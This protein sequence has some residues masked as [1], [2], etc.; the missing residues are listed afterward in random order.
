[1]AEKLSR[2]VSLDKHIDKFIEEEKNNNT[3]SK[4]GREVSL[5]TESLNATSEAKRFVDIQPE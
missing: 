4:T 2:F 1:M 3:L 5:L